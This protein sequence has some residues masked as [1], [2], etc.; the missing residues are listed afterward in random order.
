[1]PHQQRQ[2]QPH[3]ESR[4][5]LRQRHRFG[6]GRLVHHQAG[7]GENAL[8]MGAN[9]GLVDGTRAPEIVR[10]DDQPPVCSSAFRSMR[11]SRH[12]RPSALP[13]LAIQTM[14]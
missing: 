11:R 10:I 4:I 9:D 6:A 1:M 14:P 13:N 7:G 12:C 8:A 2:M 5:L 3:A